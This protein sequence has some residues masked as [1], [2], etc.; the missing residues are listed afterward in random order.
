[1]HQRTLKGLVNL[2]L[3]AEGAQG[4][5]NIAIV[6]LHRSAQ[7]LLEEHLVCL[8]NRTGRP[9]ALGQILAAVCRP[10]RRRLDQLRGGYF[11]QLDGKNAEEKIAVSIHARSHPCANGTTG[12]RT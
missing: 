5:P 10:R 7:Q 6:R 1:E 11:T 3:S 9:Q 8:R 4:F 12:S 2:P